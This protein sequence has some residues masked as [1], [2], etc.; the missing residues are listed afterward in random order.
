VCRDLSAERAALRRVT[1]DG[2]LV[3][4][5]GVPLTSGTRLD[6]HRP[7]Y[8]SAGGRLLVLPIDHGAQTMG[9]LE[10]LAPEGRPWHRSEIHRARVL[11]QLFAPIL[12]GA[13]ALRLA[14]A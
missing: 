7:E 12:T 11:A 14:A 9:V 1:P 3:T 8:A 10:V 2:T 13:G 5:G 6:A 4:V